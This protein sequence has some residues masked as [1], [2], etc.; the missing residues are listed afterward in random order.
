MRIPDILLVLPLINSR[1]VFKAN[2]PGDD[3]EHCEA[4]IIIDEAPWAN[5][6]TEFVC[7]HMKGNICC[8]QT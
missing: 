7:P 8:T 1:C 2:C 3:I 6:I 5:N 4:P